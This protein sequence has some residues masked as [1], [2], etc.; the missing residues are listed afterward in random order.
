MEVDKEVVEKLVENVNYNLTNLKISVDEY[1]ESISK[2]QTIDEVMEA[3]KRL[4]LEWIRTI[5]LD[6]YNCYFC[7]STTSCKECGYRERHGLCSAEESDYYEISDAKRKLC[8]LIE[9][10]YW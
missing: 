3:K 8:D 2:A 6:E 7:L 4:L 1:V 10:Y 5:P 9:E